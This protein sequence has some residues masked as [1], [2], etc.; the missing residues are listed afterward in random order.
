[1]D[2][3][4]AAALWA[5]RSAGGGCFPAC[6]SMGSQR[7]I[8]HPSFS[9]RSRIR[10]RLP[11]R[12]PGFTGAAPGRIARHRASWSGCG[13]SPD[14]FSEGNIERVIV[15][16]W[17]ASGLCSIPLHAR[18]AAVAFSVTAVREAVESGGAQVAGRAAW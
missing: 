18:A 17:M 1:M 4:R 12:E 6:G 2:A 7:L 14:P 15:H 3:G 8:A 13:A 16:R 10:V 11:T 9:R 5:C